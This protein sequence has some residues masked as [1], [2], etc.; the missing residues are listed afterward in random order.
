MNEMNQNVSFVEK[1][2]PWL[3]ESY[4]PKAEKPLSEKKREE[5]KQQASDK[6]PKVR[7]KVAEMENAPAEVLHDLAEDEDVSVRKAVAANRSTPHRVNII[8]A[9]D[10]D[11][12]VRLI[13]AQRLVRLLPHLS[14]HEQA[15]VYNSTV[16]ALRILAEDKV[17]NI[18]I[19]LSTSLKDVANTPPDIAKRLAED[20]EREVAEPIIRFSLSLSDDDLLGIIAS[21]PD[22][23]RLCSI[24][25]RESVS[26]SVSYAV[27]ESDLPEAQTA[28]LKN[29]SADINVQTMDIIKKRATGNATIMA[30]YNR[31]ERIPVSITNKLTRFLDD[32][33]TSFL[34]KRS[35]LED[36]VL[37]GVVE[38]ARR[39]MDW[40]ENSDREETSTMRVK[41]MAAEGT[42]TDESIADA[43]S[44]SDY[45]FVLTA[46]GYKA[47]ISS[48]IV[49][50]IFDTR[51]AKATL[52]VC[53]RAG[54]SVRLAV[55]IQQQVAKVPHNKVLYPKG[56]DE[57]PLSDED[58]RWQLEFFGIE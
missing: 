10:K 38:T 56:G 37:E 46:I 2:M 58:M 3:L 4:I 42:L 53:K 52:A 28:L 50:R 21:Q 23:W 47:N 51:S 45:E 48:I 11:Q 20:I 30:A 34:K 16:D 6:N 44:W 31:R 35:N 17:T 8:L 57:Y 14:A 5:V 49:R 25:Q 15:E 19:A 55:K 36:D 29:K 43:L 27:I 24:A 7:K 41:R 12:D 26:E 9:N 40:V 32:S 13:L 33:M 54:I 1:Y 22:G 18:R 39:R